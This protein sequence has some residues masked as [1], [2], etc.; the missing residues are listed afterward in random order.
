MGKGCRQ[1]S[2]FLPLRAAESPGYY[3]DKA[4]KAQEDGKA[5]W[6]GTVPFLVYRLELKT[7]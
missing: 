5:G 6:P 2:L 1:F 4:R 7:Q 3:T